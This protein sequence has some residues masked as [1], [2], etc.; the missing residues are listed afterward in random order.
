MV[1][2][3]VWS[4]TEAS[5]VEIPRGK[6]DEKRRENRIWGHGSILN[7]E[8]H[9]ERV[10]TD[11]YARLLCTYEFNNMKILKI[12]KIILRR[13]ASPTLHSKHIMNSLMK[14]ITNLK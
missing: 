3:L 9:S 10:S 1:N 8:N 13:S 2:I 7:E 5:A 6:A 11:N 14:E 12:T 4:S